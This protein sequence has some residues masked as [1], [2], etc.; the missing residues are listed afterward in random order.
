M[1]IS[2]RSGFRSMC[3]FR[4]DNA[5]QFIFYTLRSFFY[6]PPFSTFYLCF[7]ILKRK[8]TMNRLT[9]QRISTKAESH[10]PRIQETRLV[11][12]RRFAG[13]RRRGGRVRDREGVRIL[14]SP[15]SMSRVPSMAVIEV[16][17]DRAN[18]GE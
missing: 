10:H 9:R 3:S 15:A 8:S 13:R 17:G 14:S 16:D 1:S 6:Q 12:T 18:V 5:G 7:I 11:V 2:V 4:L